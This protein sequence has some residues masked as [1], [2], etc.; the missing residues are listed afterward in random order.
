MQTI[1]NPR[2]DIRHPT[3]FDR[4][5][6]WTPVEF[7]RPPW[8]RQSAPLMR[9]MFRS[10]TAPIPV[11]LS[12]DD[13]VAF[14]QR[15]IAGHVEH[16]LTEEAVQNVDLR[17]Q[18]YCLSYRHD[19]QPPK[20]GYHRVRRITTP[21]LRL[22]MAA[23][24]EHAADFAYTHYSIWIDSLII[25]RF[26]R[27]AYEEDD[28]DDNEHEA[29]SEEE[30]EDGNTDESDD[31][32]DYQWGDRALLPYAL[33]HVV[34]VPSPFILENDALGGYDTLLGCF[35]DDIQR[36]WIRCEHQLAASSRGLILPAT[37]RQPPRWTRS[38][39]LLQ[40]GIHYVKYSGGN[41]DPEQSL[42][43]LAMLICSGFLSRT[44][45]SYREDIELL[46]EWAM[47]L[48]C[49]SWGDR[50]RW[51]ARPRLPRRTDL[52]HKQAEVD[53]R[54]VMNLLE[55][56][57]T[58]HM[59][60]G[61]TWPRPRTRS[62]VIA[63]QRFTYPDN[64]DDKYYI[65]SRYSNKQYS[66]SGDERLVDFDPIHHLLR[67]MLVY[68]TL[69]ANDGLH[70]YLLTNLSSRCIALAARFAHRDGRH[71]TAAAAVAAAA[72]SHRGLVCYLLPKW[73]TMPIVMDV[74]LRRENG[75][76]VVCG[77]RVVHAEPVREMMSRGKMFEFE[78]C[79]EVVV[80]SVIEML[81]EFYYSKVE[82]G[83]MC[84]GLAKTSPSLWFVRA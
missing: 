7:A 48:M 65:D 18:L 74:E 58:V 12:V 25:P 76:N 64:D 45:A 81:N 41:M 31:Y 3:F 38:Q 21:R 24:R 20:N 40:S 61:R 72:R 11:S 2:L 36:T 68:R 80:R 84:V 9:L 33:C 47:S 43:M 22:A 82:K 8:C 63:L 32:E 71:L 34:A 4:S 57:A 1:A 16:R 28:D 13:A 49:N 14:V 29:Y 27:K 59:R 78:R 10:M 67:A 75:V 62:S 15:S 44:R 6:S 56:V 23:V 35:D 37:V 17:L 51:S 66:S 79:D 26:R 53:E 50:D 39:K 54:R 52:P 77:Y 19:H 55:N 30:E 70:G 60:Y 46:R 5:S 83:L 69:T 42:R 73:R